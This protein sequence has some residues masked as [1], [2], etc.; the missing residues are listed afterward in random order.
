MSS[1]YDHQA[2][3]I[4]SHCTGYKAKE[5]IEWPKYPKAMICDLT[6]AYETSD[7]KGNFRPEFE[8]HKKRYSNSSTP[9]LIPDIAEVVKENLKNSMRKMG[10]SIVKEG[11]NYKSY[12]LKKCHLLTWLSNLCPHLIR[13]RVD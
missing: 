8:T 1:E 4:E 3:V 6:K 7:D 5:I 10:T 13:N 2:A 9:K 11:L 12:V